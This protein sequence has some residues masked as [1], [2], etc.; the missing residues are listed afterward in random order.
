[1]WA[2]LRGELCCVSGLG[3]IY[4]AELSVIEEGSGGLGMAGW[5]EVIGD[6][7]C[8]GASSARTKVAGLPLMLAESLVP[9]LSTVVYMSLFEKPLWC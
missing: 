3:F 2:S 5:S 7:W 4:W 6:C 8:R 9:E 1:M